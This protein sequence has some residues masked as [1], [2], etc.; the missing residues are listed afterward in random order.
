MTTADMLIKW[1]EFSKY[2]PDRKQFTMSANPLVD[3][4]SLHIC[5]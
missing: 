3:T 5:N 2:D 4:Y 1:L